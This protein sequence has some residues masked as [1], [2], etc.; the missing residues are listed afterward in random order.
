VIKAL[1]ND[2]YLLTVTYAGTTLTVTDSYAIPCIQTLPTGAVCNNMH[3]TL[4]PNLI[5]FGRNMLVIISPIDCSAVT[6]VTSISGPSVRFYAM[7]TVADIDVSPVDAIVDGT[8]TYDSDGNVTGGTAVNY[9]KG[10]TCVDMPFG[11][12]WTAGS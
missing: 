9:L 1:Q 11:T 12:A 2:E 7:D 5:D 4:D 8:E 3:L 10:W 6:D